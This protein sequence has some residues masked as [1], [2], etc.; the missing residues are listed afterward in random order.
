MLGILHLLITA[1]SGE[2][3]TAVKFEETADVY[4]PPHAIIAGRQLGERR[5]PEECSGSYRSALV[6]QEMSDDPLPELVRDGA[7]SRRQR[8]GGC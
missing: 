4:H 2:F 3:K 8:T 6:T 5:P 7:P 1:I